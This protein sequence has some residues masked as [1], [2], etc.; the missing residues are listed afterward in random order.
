MSV[1]GMILAVVFFTIGVLGTILP[2][3]PGAPL[4]WLGMLIYGFFVKFQNLPLVFFIGQ[5]LAVLLIFFI[6]YLASIWGVR[7]YGGSR[8]AVWGSILGG[9]LGILVLGPFGLIFGPFI[10]AVAGELYRRSPLD[11]AL[12]VGFGTL[13][14][15]LGGAVLK[16]AIEAVMIIWFFMA[17]I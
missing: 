16:L 9:I 3:L 6:D 15:F 5:G 2:A 17:V 7:R 13:I 4:I 1:A 10:G 12:E 11:K 8:E 14:G